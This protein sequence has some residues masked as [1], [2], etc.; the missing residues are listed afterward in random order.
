MKEK[1]PTPLPGGPVK[2][3]SV[4]ASSGL[5]ATLYQRRKFSLT[6]AF[7]S[8][9]PST[10]SLRRLKRLLERSVWFNLISGQCQN[11]EWRKF[12][13]KGKED[14]WL[15]ILILPL[16]QLSN[17]GQITFSLGFGVFLICKIEIGLGALS[18]PLQLSFSYI[19][20]LPPS[21]PTQ[22]RYHRMPSIKCSV[23][24]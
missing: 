10:Q 1:H 18:G 24:I 11:F 9:L 3:I 22:A 6:A 8:V 7:T 15:L 16:V 21:C 12:R 17:L 19:M 13:A 4:I 20:V 23:F 14:T 5:L 2:L